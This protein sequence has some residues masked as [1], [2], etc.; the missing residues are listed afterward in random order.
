MIKKF[1][2]FWLKAQRCITV[3]WQKT[4][5]KVKT[6][7]MFGNLSDSY[8]CPCCGKHCVSFID[9]SSLYRKAICPYCNSQPRH[10]V[11][12]LYLNEQ[13]NISSEKLKVLHFAPEAIFRRAFSS[14]SNL[15]YTTADLNDPSV[16]IK[17][18]V[19]KIPYPDMTFDV[20]FC[21]HVLEHVEN[22][23]KAMCE[24]LRILKPGGWASL[25]VPMDNQKD[26]TFEDPNIVSPDDRLRY[27]GQEDH[28]RLYGLDY[29]DRLEQAGF[30]VK[31]EKY[32][33]NLSPEQF[34]KYGL[35]ISEDLYFGIRPTSV[36]E[37]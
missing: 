13:T 1:E 30:M 14:M 22:D 25:Q 18:D 24:L 9:W 35:Y 7:L 4:T 15:D 32:A 23:H 37:G 26:K 27:F 12:W 31:I 5:V 8:F 11:L 16:D 19:T 10:R 6:S 17:I 2:I 20:I 21:D 34:K 29:K 3:T 33:K 28:V 36:G